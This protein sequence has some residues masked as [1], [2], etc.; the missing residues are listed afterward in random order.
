MTFLLHVTADSCS[1]VVRNGLLARHQTCHSTRQPCS[2]SLIADIRES[3]RPVVTN[4][5]QQSWFPD[6]LLNM[7]IHMRTPDFDIIKLLVRASPPFTLS[8]NLVIWTI[9][10]SLPGNV[11]EVRFLRR[12]QQ[13]SA[14]GCRSSLCRIPWSNPAVECSFL[15]QEP[16]LKSPVIYFYSQCRFCR[17]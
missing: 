5:L 13:Y 9:A 7:A 11:T 17:S 1:S 16:W 3:F 15:E 4:I 8:C 10:T 12:L 6:Q 2:S 14:V